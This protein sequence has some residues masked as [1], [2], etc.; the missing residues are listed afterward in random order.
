MKGQHIGPY[1]WHPWPVTSCKIGQR[2]LHSWHFNDNLLHHK[3][4]GAGPMKKEVGE[5]P[6]GIPRGLRLVKEGMN[7]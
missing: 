2:Q 7:E 3:R 4:L 5:K 1:H 6:A